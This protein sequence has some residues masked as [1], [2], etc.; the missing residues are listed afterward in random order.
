MSHATIQHVSQYCY[1]T[2]CI[3]FQ[4]H[5]GHHAT[6]FTELLFHRTVMRQRVSY[7][8]V[9]CHHATCFTVLLLDN[10]YHI[11]M[12][13]ATMQHVSQNCCFTELL[14]DNVYHISMSHAT[15]QHVSQ[16]CYETTCITFQCHMPPCNMFHRTV[17]RQ[18]VSHF[19]VTCHHA[20]CFTAKLA[21]MQQTAHSS[22]TTQ[23]I[24]D[25]CPVMTDRKNP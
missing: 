18:R 3:I 13:H 21:I 20:T 12:S 15:M 2:T 23:H 7:F 5:T 11:S 1:E 8:N 19:N 14:W 17:M 24:L 4:C 10:V 6:C 25:R 16:Y 9:T 22:Q